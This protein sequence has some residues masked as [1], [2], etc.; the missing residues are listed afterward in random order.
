MSMQSILYAAQRDK[1]IS[2]N[3]ARYLWTQISSRGWKTQEPA[4]LDFPHDRPTVLPSILKAH[5][6]DLG[7][8]KSE[9]AHLAYVYVKELDR[10]YPYGNADKERPRI[11]IIN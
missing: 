5:V 2:P 8:S 4:S 11:R 10:L 1:L 7:F 3:Q 9:I 6:D